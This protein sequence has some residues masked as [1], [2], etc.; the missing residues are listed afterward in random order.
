MLRQLHSLAGLVAGLLLAVVALTGATLSVFPALE[1]ARA[2]DAGGLDVATLAG[3]VQARLPGVQ[4]L[5][6]QPSGLLVAYH[7]AG[8][9]VMAALIPPVLV[10]TG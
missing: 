1:R 10:P 9:G 5:V 7:E 3:R 8:H 2:G 6:R 4:T